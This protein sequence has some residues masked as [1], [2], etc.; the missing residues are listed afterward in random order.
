MEGTNRYAILDKI[1]FGAIFIMG[2][3]LP[4]FF[5]P[6]DGIPL[7]ASKGI[8]VSV[9][10]LLSFSLW[11]LGRLVYGVFS[12]SK[13]I[14]FTG[15]VLVGFS[16]LIASVVSLAPRVSL[17]GQGFE[18]TTFAFT[19]VVLILLF[20]SSIFFQS[21]ERAFYFYGGVLLSGIVVPI[22]QLVR[23]LWTG[24]I[25]TFNIFESQVSNLV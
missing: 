18:I 21:R 19:V 6:I 13:S 20:L 24:D 15:G 1:S 4:I 22:Y 14:I 23:L 11:L 9:A 25:M 12:F 16:A 7:D 5:L 17:I 3:L 10:V 2:V 8:L